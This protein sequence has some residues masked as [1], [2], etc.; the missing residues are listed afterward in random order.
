M[1]MTTA[2]AQ[3][4]TLDQLTDEL[5]AAGWDSTQ[6]TREEALEAVLALIAETSQVEVCGN[7]IEYDKSG[8]GHCWV[9]AQLIDCPASIQEEIACEII[10]GGVDTCD[11]YRASNGVFYRW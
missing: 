2:Q 4:A 7:A 1:A 10:D 8:V 6:Q 9:A 5:A 11:S 3:V